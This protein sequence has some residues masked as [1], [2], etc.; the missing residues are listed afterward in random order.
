MKDALKD[1][2]RSGHICSI[3]SLGRIVIPSSMRKN[4]DM[5]KGKQIELIGVEGGILL[6]KYEP[7]C[8]FCGNIY[9][10]TIF[11]GRIVCKDC[12]ERM[13]KMLR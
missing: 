5:E 9:D 7:G 4:Y 13:A 3:D 1:R 12:I 11:Q 10:L 2:N 8:M 6:R